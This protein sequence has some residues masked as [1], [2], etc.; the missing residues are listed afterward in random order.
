MRTS[1]VTYKSKII[2]IHN[3]FHTYCHRPILVGLLTNNKINTDVNLY[4]GMLCRSYKLINMEVM[5]AA[6]VYR[7]FT[8]SIC[9][10]QV[11]HHQF[12]LQHII[13]VC[14]YGGKI[15]VSLILVIMLLVSRYFLRL[16]ILVAGDPWL[17]KAFGFPWETCFS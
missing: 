14:Y 11:W 6:H 15:K 1:G 5:R 17:W 13:E 4:S 10:V 2:T 8:E 9:A 3:F 7:R 12:P 16:K